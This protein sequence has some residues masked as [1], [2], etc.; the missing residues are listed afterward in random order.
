MRLDR[1]AKNRNR[2]QDRQQKKTEIGRKLGE[3]NSPYSPWITVVG[4]KKSDRNSRGKSPGRTWNHFKKENFICNQPY[5]RH[6]FS[7]W[8]DS[9][10]PRF[11]LVHV[12]LSNDSFVKS[13]QLPWWL[14]SCM[15][16]FGIQTF[17]RGFDI[18][19]CNCLFRDPE[20]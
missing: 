11:L 13:R 1:L 17:H 10:E 12:F 19:S 7:G 9:L 3:N 20:T 15:I 2:Q 14:T 4:R 6:L 18:S 5:F 16:T 8:V